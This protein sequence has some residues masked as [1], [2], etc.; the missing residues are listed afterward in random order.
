MAPL[1]KIFPHLFDGA[2]RQ[3][4]SSHGPKPHADQQGRK[5]KF[6]FGYHFTRPFVISGLPSTCVDNTLAR[7]GL[8]SNI[9][10]FLEKIASQYQRAWPRSG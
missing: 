9:G 5:S 3:Q 7:D 8:L 2:G 6:A 10:R 1:T 4:H